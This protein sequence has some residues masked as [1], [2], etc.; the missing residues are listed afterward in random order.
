MISIFSKSIDPK[1]FMLDQEY[2]VR[3]KGETLSVV[4]PSPD[5]TRLFQLHSVSGVFGALLEMIVVMIRIG[6]WSV[7]YWST[8][9]EWARWS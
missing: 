9:S 7:E 3:L 2:H 4:A 1:F 6:Y 8:E 5:S